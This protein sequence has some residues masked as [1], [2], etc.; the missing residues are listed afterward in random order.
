MEL[1]RR[2][3]PEDVQLYYQIG[4]TGRRDLPLAPDARSGFEMTLL[5]ML[6]FRPQTAAADSGP[7]TKPDV[8][9]TRRERPETQPSATAVQ[10][11]A[12]AG[13]ADIVN[14][15]ALKGMLHQLAVNCELEAWQDNRIRLRLDEA[16][17]HLGST[18]RTRRLEQCLSDYA[19]E[20]ITLDIVIASPAGETPAVRDQRV[21]SQRQQQAESEIRNNSQVKKLQEVFNATIVADS[22][23]PTESV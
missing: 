16:H 20:A 15:L 17:A 9:V 14:K 1:A 12:T 21:R 10:Q 11:Q 4:L 22:I 6:A 19:G 18:S 5:R 7:Q 3:A 2:L 23:Q 8:A 13:W